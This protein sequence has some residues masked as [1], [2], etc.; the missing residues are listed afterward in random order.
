MQSKYKALK[1]PTGDLELDRACRLVPRGGAFTLRITADAD[2]LGRDVTLGS[3]LLAAVPTSEGTERVCP[4]ESCLG[5]E[6]NRF[7]KATQNSWSWWCLCEDRPGA[8][9][10]RGWLSVL[11]IFFFTINRGHLGG[12]IIGHF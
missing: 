3:C 12:W 8:L 1:N 6:T 7:W 2:A 9:R 11:S 5:I 4:P 10:G